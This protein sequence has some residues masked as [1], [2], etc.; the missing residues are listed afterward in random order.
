MIQRV[1]KLKPDSP[2]LRDYLYVA[3]TYKDAKD[4]P[5]MVDLR[6]Q[7]SPVVDQ[8]ELGSCTANAIASGL[9]EYLLLKAKQV[10][11][12]LSRLFLY[13][14]ERLLEGTVEEDSGATI[15]DG[16]KVLKT[17]G[18]CPETDYPYDIAKF[19]DPP[20]EQ[21]LE[22]A[23]QYTI[24]EYHRVTSLTKLKTALAEEQPVVIGFYVYSS[25]ESDEVAATGIV[26]MPN[27]WKEELLGGHAVLV[28]GYD[29]AKEWAIVRNSWGE[30]WGDKGYFYL[31]YKYWSSGLVTDMW[32]GSTGSVPEKSFF[33]K[34]LDW[35]FGLFNCGR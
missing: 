21:A 23:K 31:P 4:L 3:K 34:M 35:F 7:C 14:E 26:P 24:S 12:A 20:T 19:T 5:S 6:A 10:W 8:G 11:V 15:R 17:I 28:V 25:F 27:T 30:N 1:Y 18:V 33:R 9:R 16:M 29:D 13:Y 32:T 22:D 2:D